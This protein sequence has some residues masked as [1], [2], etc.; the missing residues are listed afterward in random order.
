LFIFNLSVAEAIDLP[1]APVHWTIE[2]NKSDNEVIDV[3]F[4]NGGSAEKLVLKAILGAE[5]E[6]HIL[7]YELNNA[8]IA[9]ALI[10]IHKKVAV[11]V[12][13]SKVSKNSVIP[14]LLVNNIKVKIDTTQTDRHS[15]FIIVDEK[16][17]GDGDY[18]YCVDRNTTLRKNI[19]MTWNNPDLAKTYLREWTAHWDSAKPFL[20]K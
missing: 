18:D 13:V 7:S 10:N 9:Q 6:I 2:E 5:S 20:S 8:K 14:L 12:I 1:I 11:S 3:G 17:S 19:M 16:H 4:S 15:K